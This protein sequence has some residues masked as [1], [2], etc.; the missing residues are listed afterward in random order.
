MAHDP[1]L[2]EVAATVLFTM[3]GM[4][5]VT[6]GDEIGMGGA[7]GEVGRRPMPWDERR[8]DATLFE[9]Y[10]RLAALR[11]HSPARRRGGLRWV[12]AGPDHMVHLREEAQETALVHVAG[13]AHEAV[14]LNSRRLPGVGGAQVASGRSPVTGRG[15]LTLT[16]PGPGVSVLTW[17]PTRARRRR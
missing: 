13:G 1:R 15:T 6:Y 17:R 9:T 11:R 10:C 12:S 3:S 4:P 2:A 8:W 16:A 14:V 5:M 7:Y